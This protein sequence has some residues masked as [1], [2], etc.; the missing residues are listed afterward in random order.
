LICDSGRELLV[1]ISD[2]NCVEPRS[3]S[4]QHRQKVRSDACSAAA[5]ARPFLRRKKCGAAAY[6][7]PVI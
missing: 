2:K 1:V 7:R 5:T 4:V 3:S 6:A